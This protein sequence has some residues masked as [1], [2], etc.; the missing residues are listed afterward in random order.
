ML[1]SRCELKTKQQKAKKK[2]RTQIS[3]RANEILM[4]EF[5]EGD[6]CEEVDK[7]SQGF[8]GELVGS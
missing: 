3:K 5:L 7:G 4:R 2:E 1:K 8:L 6:T